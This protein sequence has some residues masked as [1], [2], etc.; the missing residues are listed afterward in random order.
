MKYCLVVL[1]IFLKLEHAFGQKASIQFPM[2]SITGK[3]MYRGVV[4][5]PGANAAELYQR[6]HGWLARYVGAHA[7]GL[8]D[9]ANGVLVARYH[10]IYTKRLLLGQ[11]PMDVQRTLTITVREGRYRYEMTDFMARNVLQSY[12]YYGVEAPTVRRVLGPYVSQ[13]ATQE[14]TA[15]SAAM[16]ASSARKEK[17]W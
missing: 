9:P 15:L 13:V 8:D 7:I 3:I 2:D 12:T 14:I 16:Q 5:V 4:L 6:A 17:P 1:C 10:S 11:Y